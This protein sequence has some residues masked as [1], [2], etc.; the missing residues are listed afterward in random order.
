MGV[1]VCVCVCV[2]VHMYFVS[3]SRQ[4]LIIISYNAL[5]NEEDFY[6][7]G[8]PGNHSLLYDQIYDWDIWFA[9]WQVD[10]D[11]DC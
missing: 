2:W 3:N 10:T 5:I 8:Q 4:A 1:F 11:S 6:Y 9:K 7:L